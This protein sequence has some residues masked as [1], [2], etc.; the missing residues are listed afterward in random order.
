MSWPHLLSRQRRTELTT[1]CS[2]GWMVEGVIDNI[3]LY[4]IRIYTYHIWGSG[5]RA[6]MYMCST[7]QMC[8]A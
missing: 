5:L 3:I 7:R 2:V 1:V 8:K 4:I 6:G